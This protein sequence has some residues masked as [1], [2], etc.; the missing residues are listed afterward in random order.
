MT[1]RTMQIASGRVTSVSQQTISTEVWSNNLGWTRQSIEEIALQLDTHDAPLTV[2]TSGTRNLFIVA[3]DRLTVAYA[4]NQ[5][6]R[7]IYGIRNTTDG[8]VYL[9]RT[10]K[11]ASGRTDVF[12]TIGLLVALAFIGGIMCA[13][14]R[15]TSGMLDAF[16]WFASGAIG[17]FVLSTLLRIVF[18]V[19][20]WP[21]IRRLAQP[22]G[23]REMNA[24]RHA[25]SLA[26]E[27]TPHIRF[28]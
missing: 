20:V 2:R 16:A 14:S 19:I 17:L 24:A 5:D 10:A 13:V 6:R 11:V 27:D 28:I 8:S 9:V 23:K 12:V 26:K 15:S 3:G 22:G 4:P 18:G 21:E 25:L 7:A 1:D